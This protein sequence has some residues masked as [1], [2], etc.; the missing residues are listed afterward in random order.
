MLF[1]N[2]LLNYNGVLKLSLFKS[3][4]HFNELR[5]FQSPSFFYF[6]V[7]CHCILCQASPPPPLP[8]QELC[9]PFQPDGFC[10]YMKDTYRQRV[11]HLATT[12][13]V[14]D[15]FSCTRELRDIVPGSPEPFTCS[16][17]K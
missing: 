4:F 14:L 17:S 3:C 11:H 16:K 1:L 8:L 9:S 6:H 13:P 10:L 2:F 5:I 12:V 15:F 7:K